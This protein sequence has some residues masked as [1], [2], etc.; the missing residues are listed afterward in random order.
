MTTDE[1]RAAL[2]EKVARETCDAVNGAGAYD[3]TL[4]IHQD[5]VW[6]PIATAAIDVALEEAAMV[7]ESTPQQFIVTGMRCEVVDIS[8]TIAAAIRALKEAP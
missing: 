8:K 7:A 1:R 2:V 5:A 6:K 3:E 4:D